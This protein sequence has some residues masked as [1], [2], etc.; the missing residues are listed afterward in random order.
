MLVASITSNARARKAAQ[1][2]RAN[3]QLTR[4]QQAFARQLQSNVRRINRQTG[5]TAATNTS[6][7]MARPDFM[8]LLPIF[9]Q[10]LI[11]SRYHG[12]NCDEIS[13]AACTVFQ[14]YC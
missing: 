1:P 8:E 7:I 14:I 10:K 2:V 9:V 3:V 5:I 11:I 4:D 6:N 12:F 13:S